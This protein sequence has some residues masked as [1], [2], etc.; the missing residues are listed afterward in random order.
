MRK[1]AAL[2]PEE[3]AAAAAAAAAAEEAPAAAGAE[4][5]GEDGAA[6]GAA[7]GLP[8]VRVVLPADFALPESCGGLL[9]DLAHTVGGRD[10]AGV[11]GGT[12]F[13]VFR[14]S[15][16]VGLSRPLQGDTHWAPG[17]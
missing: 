11:G 15:C 14:W 16:S 8:A 17:L 1:L 12:A 10:G 4:G 3:A 2:Q 9:E 13:C 7:A 6:A 5:E